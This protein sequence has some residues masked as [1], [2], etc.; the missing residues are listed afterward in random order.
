MGLRHFTWRD[1]AAGQ[2]ETLEF[3]VRR[4]PNEDRNRGLN[5]AE[6]INKNHWTAPLPNGVAVT[7][8]V[9]SIKSEKAE[10][11]DNVGWVI[12]ADE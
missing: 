4:R 2:N 8:R 3:F 7:G 1:I 9:W 6:V 11:G 10:L 5:T 12:V